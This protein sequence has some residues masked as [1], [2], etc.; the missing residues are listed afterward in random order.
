MA[1]SGNNSGSRSAVGILGGTFDPIH[2]GHLRPAQEAFALLPLAELRFVPASAPPLRPSP[3]ASA[4]QRIAMLRLAIADH[5]GLVVDDRELRRAGPSYTVDTLES[6]RAELGATPLCLLI[7]M[8]QFHSFERWH[9]WREILELAHVVV[10]NR[11]GAEAGTLPEWAR[12]RQTAD[13]AA[14]SHAPAGRLVFLGVQ[15]QDISA[16]RIR[17]ARARGESIAGLVPEAVR[18]YIEVHNLYGHSDRGD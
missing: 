17:A 10:F 5:P 3:H 2:Y 11:P 18:E 8:D 15:P 4:G 14:L 7:G 13:F 16:T 12:S 9:R 1:T 6:L